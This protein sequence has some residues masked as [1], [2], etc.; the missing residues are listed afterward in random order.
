MTARWH[1]AV[2]PRELILVE[3]LLGDGAAAPT[4]FAPREHRPN[5]RDEGACV[6]RLV[7]RI[8]GAGL[9]HEPIP[10]GARAGAHQHHGYVLVLVVAA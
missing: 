2:R 7:E 3:H 10:D 1:D 8:D 5:D 9:L 4:A 6:E